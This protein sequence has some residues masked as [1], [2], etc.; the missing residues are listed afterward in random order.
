MFVSPGHAQEQS[1]LILL[2][3]FFLIF[4][5]L[6]GVTF[7]CDLNF[8]VNFYVN[9]YQEKG[10]YVSLGEKRKKKN[11]D[12]ERNRGRY[13]CN[14]AKQDLLSGY[15]NAIRK[16]DDSNRVLWIGIFGE[17]SPTKSLPNFFFFFL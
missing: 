14:M 13:T 4:H 10:F 3:C 6:Q 11:K 12:K 17:K 7:S 2:S 9:R 5:Y 1:A 16:N 15:D 8:Y